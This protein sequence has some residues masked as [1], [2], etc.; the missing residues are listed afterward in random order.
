MKVG[1]KMDLRTEIKQRGIDNED[2][3][4]KS[5]FDRWLNGEKINKEDYEFIL[6]KMQESID[7]KNEFID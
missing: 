4:D 2:I 3:F 5:I 6:D 7:H 1:D